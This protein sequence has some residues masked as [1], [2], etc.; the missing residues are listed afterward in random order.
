MN[1][2]HPWRRIL[3]AFGAILLAAIAITLFRRVAGPPGPVNPAGEV[4]STRG[5][6][7][8]CADPNNLPF[9]NDRL[10]GFENRLMELVGEELGVRV[11]YQWWA[12]RRG[13]FRNTLNSGLCDVV[14]GI[15]TS[16]EL[17]QST[18][19]YYRSTYVFVSQRSRGLDVASF[20]DPRL[21]ALRIGVTMIGD[22]YSN[23]PPAHALAR[24]QISTNVV[25]F[26]VYGD[27][28]KPNP[29]ARIMEA[30]RS[31][32][33]DLAV[34]WGPLA[35]YFARSAAPELRLEPVTPQIE[36]PFLP[37]VFDIG[38]GVRR[39]NDSLR[40]ALDQVIVRRRDDIARIL[41]EF[42]VPDLTR[43]A[44]RAEGDASPLDEPRV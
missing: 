23:S 26:T 21:R 42:G 32:E 22:D 31:G 33:V 15:P 1:N 2:P 16:I 12:Q 30:V 18:R 19:P 3:I 8:V 40:S 43:R 37:F 41:V 25:G 13:F 10:E 4:G 35:G 34:V 5:V 17:A 9:S 38:M 27:Y 28:S 24:R 44:R 39:G 20:D 11:E 29:T 14:P 6:L 7:R 36:P